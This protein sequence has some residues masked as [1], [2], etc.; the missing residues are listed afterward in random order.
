MKK[1]FLILILFSLLSFSA[2]LF[3]GNKNVKIKSVTSSTP[4]PNKYH[5]INKVLGCNEKTVIKKY[6]YVQ[7]T[8]ELE[9]YI[10]NE[11]KNKKINEASVYFRDLNAGPTFGIGVQEDFI[12]ASLLKVP[13]LI[14]YLS[15]IEKDPSL[16][17][18]T[19]KY[20]KVIGTVTQ[21]LDGIVPLQQDKLYTIEELLD[22]MIIYSDNLA[23]GL[24]IKFLERTYPQ[25]NL[26]EQT[27]KDLGLINPIDV[28]QNIASV[29]GY[30]S[31]FRQLSQVAIFHQTCLK[32]L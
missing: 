12:P 23:Y 32:K 21:E 4:C 7:L 31:V 8:N 29:K 22:R 1:L 27:M 24:L 20:S 17:K 5:F 6:E 19:T 10:N 16:L 2:G 14:T 26:H 18:K 13:L 30:A 28:T 15:L 3:I 11:I 9:E 25:Q